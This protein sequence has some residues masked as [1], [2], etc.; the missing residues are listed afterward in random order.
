M[1]RV[2]INVDH[3]ATVRQAR[4]APEPD[5]VTAAALVELAG[6]HGVVVHL[7][8]DRRHIQDRD[9][10]ILRKT[11]KTRLNLEM[12]ATQEMI[13]IALRIKPDIV[14][15]VPEKRQELTTEGGLDV[16]LYED[17]LR[18]V[19]KV[20]HQ[21][22]IPVSLFI[23]PDPKQ[24]KTAHKIEADCVEIHTGPFA[25]AATYIRRQEEFE[26]VE[27][28]AKL[29]AKLGLAVHAGHG[30]DY[31]NILWLR[32]I[33]EIEEF[34]IGHAVIAR[35][36]LVGLERA[37]REMIALVTGSWQSMG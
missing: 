16:V 25:E 36:V 29:A 22:G 37:V 12:A 3:V 20:L 7:R 30:V 19:I 21:G 13:Q 28:A 35:A 17:N 24:I 32:N 9:V 5:P 27:N 8:E 23:N 18:E 33:R 11:V 31:R 1:A 10:E 26:R 34:S 2:A 15:L 6:A 4:L 14:T